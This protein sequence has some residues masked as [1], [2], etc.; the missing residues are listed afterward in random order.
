M[1]LQCQCWR[2]WQIE[3]QGVKDKTLCSLSLVFAQLGH[4]DCVCV[5]VC[6]CVHALRRKGNLRDSILG[7]PKVTVSEECFIDAWC[8]YWK[9][10]KWNMYSQMYFY[11]V[12]ALMQPAWDQEMDHY[13]LHAP[14]HLQSLPPKDGRYPDFQQHR[15]KCA[16]FWTT[17]TRNHTA[18]TLSYLVSF[19]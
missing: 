15:W 18:S 6:V 11:K 12:N 14:C 4:P 13:N 7:Y 5:C 1:Y 8:T 19:T 3:N 9:A 2:S 16:C 17:L 10:W